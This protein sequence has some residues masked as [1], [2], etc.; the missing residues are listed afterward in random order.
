MSYTR[1]L[2]A[3]KEPVTEIEPV[4]PKCTPGPYPR[5]QI[6]VLKTHPVNLDRSFTPSLGLMTRGEDKH[7]VSVATVGVC[8][9]GEPENVPHKQPGSKLS[10]LSIR[11][12][13]VKV[14]SS[15]QCRPATDIWSR[16]QVHP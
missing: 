12:F 2:A 4:L 9:L 3:D 1:V 8:P 10:S 13:E 14:G 11:I 5:T 15:C 7:P 6:T 16:S